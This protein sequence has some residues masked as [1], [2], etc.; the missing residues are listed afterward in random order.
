MRV[1]MPVIVAVPMVMIMV[2]RV[3]AI[4]VAVIPMPM[5]MMLIRMPMI[6]MMTMVLRLLLLRLLLLRLLMMRRGLVMLAQQVEAVVVA[7]GRA[8]DRVHV[9]FRRLRVGQEHTGVVVELDERHR[10]L[11]AVIERAFLRSAADPAEVRVA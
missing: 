6:V 10:A 8:H 1:C 7:V 4:V 3:P 2:M 5:M 11:D 9:E